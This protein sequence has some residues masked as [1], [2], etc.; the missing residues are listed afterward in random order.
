[1]KRLGLDQFTLLD[2]I[3]RRFGFRYA[4]VRQIKVDD[5]LDTETVFFAAKKNGYDRWENMPDLIPDL[6]AVNRVTPGPEIFSM[7]YQQFYGWA[8]KKYPAMKKK[9]RKSFVVT[10]RHRNKYAKKLHRAGKGQSDS[11][12][13]KLGQRSNKSLNYYTGN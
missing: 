13:R 10:H 1:M 8:K 3:M 7:T 4:D 9:G 6:I 5:I 12:A 11:I 2:E